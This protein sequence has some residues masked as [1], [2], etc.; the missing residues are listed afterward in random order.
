MGGAAVSEPA[1]SEP[2][3]SA[4][5]VTI[6]RLLFPGVVAIPPGEQVESGEIDVGGAQHITV[7]VAIGRIGAS[8]Q[9]RIV[10]VRRAGSSLTQAPVFTDTL[11]PNADNTVAHLN[12][13]L[14]V[15]SPSLRVVLTNVGTEQAVLLP[16]WAYGVRLAPST[17]VPPPEPPS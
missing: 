3:V 7:N 14:P 12:V 2:A 8:V 13:F 16:S 4:V 10:F 17:F 11:E 6:N 15:H 9:C 5:P 1:V